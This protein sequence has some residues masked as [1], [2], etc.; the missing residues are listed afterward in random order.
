MFQKSSKSF[1]LTFPKL[2]SQNMRGFSNA[3][4]LMLSFHGLHYIQPW[5]HDSQFVD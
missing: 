2:S 1:A 4:I 5:D 3:A